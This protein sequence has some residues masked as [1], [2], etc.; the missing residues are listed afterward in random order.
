MFVLIIVSICGVRT[1]N[2]N[3]AALLPITSDNSLLE[4]KVKLV[5]QELDGSAIIGKYHMINQR[6]V[7]AALELCR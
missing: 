6:V 1:C 3:T 7:A 2:G 5:V 4:D